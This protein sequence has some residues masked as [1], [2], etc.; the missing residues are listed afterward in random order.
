MKN[1]KKSRILSVF[2]SFWGEKNGI[3]T[4]FW[5]QFL[6]VLVGVSLLAGCTSEKKRADKKKTTRTTSTDVKNKKP[7]G[8]KIKEGPAPLQKKDDQEEEFDFLK[9]PRYK[10]SLEPIAEVKEDSHIDILD[11]KLKNGIVY[12]CTAMQG[13]Q[14]YDVKNPLRPKE[15]GEALFA[16]PYGHFRHPSCRYLALGKGVAFATSS[17]SA[18]QPKPFIAAIHIDAP[19]NPKVIHYFSREGLNPEGIA[20]SGELVLTASHNSGLV[21][22]RWDGKKL[23]E[24]SRLNGFK[25][26]W[27]VA[28]WRKRYALVSDG[29]GGLHLVDISEPKK[30]KRVKKIKL[31]GFSRRISV[32]KDLALVSL[33]QSGFSI[34]SVSSKGLKLLSLVEMPYSAVQI[35]VSGQ[36]AFVAGWNQLRVYDISSPHTPKLLAAREFHRRKDTFRMPYEESLSRFRL[37]TLAIAP[38]YII[39]GEWQ[40]L[41]TIRYSEKKLPI[42]TY[43]MAEIFVGPVSPGETASSQLTITNEGHLPLFIRAKAT[44]RHFRVEPEKKKIPPGQTV[45][46]KVWFRTKQRGLVKSVLN[47]ESND[48]HREKVK[49]PL[50]GGEPLTL[51]KK[52]YNFTLTSLTGNTLTLKK[53]RGHIVLLSYFATF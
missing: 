33:G 45:H 24:I 16:P 11:I 8:K 13:F 42:F 30:L 9:V 35:E 52:H 27:D 21:V 14:T 47:I 53:L 3:L 41:R 17:V 15:L 19:S 20:V 32:H 34:V 29:Y 39:A 48:P 36:R 1:K 5:R 25:N 49:I 6:P 46:L 26:A 31:P 50:S 44:G 37:A 18:A 7:N 2:Q 4:A 28:V 43:D 40:G 38:P 51:G 23:R 10:A 12:A 22:L